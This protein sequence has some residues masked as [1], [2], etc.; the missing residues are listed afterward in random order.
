MAL[1]PLR[2]TQHDRF[3]VSLNRKKVWCKTRSLTN[4]LAA[5]SEINIFSLQESQKCP[6]IRSLDQK[7]FD[8]LIWDSLI[9]YSAL[10]KLKWVV[11]TEEILLCIN[12]NNV[13][14]YTVPILLSASWRLFRKTLLVTTV[15]C[16]C[17][18][19]VFGRIKKEHVGFFQILKS[20]VFNL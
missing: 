9:Y 1:A 6:Y 15:K 4:I 3:S 20:F 11:K 17:E 10:R 16:S 5:I 13:A 2:R 14:S 19:R 12:K 18:L 7:I 8:I